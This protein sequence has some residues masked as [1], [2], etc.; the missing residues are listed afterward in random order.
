ML[1]NIN[2]SKRVGKQIVF[3]DL[4]GLL[5]EIPSVQLCQPSEI[6]IHPDSFTQNNPVLFVWQGDYSM[7]QAAFVNLIVPF[8]MKIFYLF[9]FMYILHYISKS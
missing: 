5:Q 6:T 7:F 9:P 1:Y 3:L 4:A 2:L 8:T